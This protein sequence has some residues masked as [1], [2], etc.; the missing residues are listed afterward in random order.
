MYFIERTK[1]VTYLDSFGNKYWVSCNCCNYMASYNYAV[2]VWCHANLCLNNFSR[3]TLS[4]DKGNEWTFHVNMQK[5][6]ASTF[7][8]LKMYLP[9]NCNLIALSYW[10]R[11]YKRCLWLHKM[12]TQAT[13]F[14]DAARRGNLNLLRE[15]TWPWIVLNTT[16]TAFAFSR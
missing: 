2:C 10:K 5:N 6:R 7:V 8:T 4:S 15:P 11:V 1:D 13:G 14:W 3:V 16:K 12:Q 9:N